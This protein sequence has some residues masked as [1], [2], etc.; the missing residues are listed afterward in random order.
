MNQINSLYRTKKSAEIR[1]T[2]A[3][4][5]YGIGKKPFI[6]E[7][8]PIITNGGITGFVDNSLDRKLPPAS[9]ACKFVIEKIIDGK[10]SGYFTG[11][12]ITEGLK[13]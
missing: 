5:Y 13:P 12:M 11:G 7:F 4:L 1:N 6:K 3:V 10:A 2:E 9:P 8:S